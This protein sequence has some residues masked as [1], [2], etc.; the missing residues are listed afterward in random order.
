VFPA[1]LAERVIRYWSFEDDVVLDP[2]AGVGTVGM[3]AARLGRRFV[4]SE[5]E[6][7]YLA[8][9]RRDLAPWLTS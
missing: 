8:V 9:M 4:L 5:L 7:R 6:E 3:V 2:F 1:S